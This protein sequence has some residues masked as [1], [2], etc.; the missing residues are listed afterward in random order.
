MVFTG[1]AYRLPV[2]VMA[3]LMGLYGMEPPV[4]VLTFHC[5]ARRYRSVSS[6]NSSV[7]KSWCIWMVSTSWSPQYTSTRFAMYGEGSTTVLPDASA[8]SRNSTESRMSM[9]GGMTKSCVV[10]P[11]A[12]ALGSDVAACTIVTRATSSCTL[13][14]LDGQVRVTLSRPR[15]VVSERCVPPLL[16]TVG[17]GEMSAVAVAEAN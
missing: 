5:G 14:W 10:S 11:P 17:M 2:D 15:A 1:M 8:C 4:V 13:V 3:V 6:V 12:H 16:T 9:P 7:W